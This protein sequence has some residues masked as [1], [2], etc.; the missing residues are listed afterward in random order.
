[1]LLC[2]LVT[3]KA[4]V[5]AMARRFWWTGIAVTSVALAAGAVLVGAFLARV[6]Y[7]GV[8][9]GG[10]LLVAVLA[11]AAPMVFLVGRR[12]GPAAATAALAGALAIVYPLV[13]VTTARLDGLQP[14][15]ALGRAVDSLAGS[16]DRVGILGTVPA[17]GLVFYSRHDVVALPSPEAVA[18]FLQAGERAFCVL[19]RQH[20]A[21][22]SALAPDAVHEITASSKLVVRFNRLA[23]RARLYDDD[24]VLVSNDAA[25]S[26]SKE[27]SNDVDGYRPG[28]R[29]STVAGSPPT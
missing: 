9:T 12:V 10:V 23:G 1:A 5:D 17:P 22:V 11:A 4:S 25:R 18:A 27:P 26:R 3:D 20:L 29:T 8:L 16:Q 14:I 2:G 15:P 7:G 24:L 6:G 13:A 28:T 19:P 21:T